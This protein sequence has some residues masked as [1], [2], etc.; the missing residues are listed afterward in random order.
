MTTCQRTIPTQVP[1]WLGPGALALDT[2]TGWAGVIQLFRDD[3]GSISIDAVGHPTHAILRPVGGLGAS[4]R[5]ALAH[6][7]K[8]EGTR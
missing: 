4:W 8:P 1:R 7:K 5:A 3:R 6:L 2:N